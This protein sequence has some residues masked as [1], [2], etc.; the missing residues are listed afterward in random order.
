LAAPPFSCA[1]RAGVKWS[2]DRFNADLPLAFDYH[3]EQQYKG[4]AFFHEK[5]S[6]AQRTEDD[7]AKL[8][9]CAEHGISLLVVPKTAPFDGPPRA[10]L[11]EI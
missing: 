10:Y 11:T 4:I 1:T 7:N 5:S 3:G 8:A 2:S 9:H 6:L